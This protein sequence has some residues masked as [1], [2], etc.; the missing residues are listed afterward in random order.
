MSDLGDD[1]LQMITDK[2]KVS[3]RGLESLASRA[4]R[5][6]EASKGLAAE[7][8]SL[9]IDQEIPHTPMQR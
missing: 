4:E 5:V 1:G 6:R 3:F 9:S 7:R 2:T 8:S